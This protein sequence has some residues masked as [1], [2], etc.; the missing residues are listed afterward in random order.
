MMSQIVM[1]IC[2]AR[3]R[4]G[5]SKASSF[6]ETFAPSVVMYLSSNSSSTYRRIRD[7]LP[8]AASPTRQTFVFIRRVSGI[9]G[10]RAPFDSAEPT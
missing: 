6:F 9:G 5:R 2:T 7:V 3:S 1:S 8:T 10:L 4:S